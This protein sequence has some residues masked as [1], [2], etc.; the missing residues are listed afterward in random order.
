MK[1]PAHKLPYFV[2]VVAMTAPWVSNFP[3]MGP[4]YWMPELLALL[5]FAFFATSS[6]LDTGFKPTQLLLILLFTFHMMGQAVVG[7]G[8]GG[9]SVTSLILVTS[10]FFVFL[11]MKHVDALD[12]QIIRQLSVLYAV[13]VAFVLFEMLLLK[14]GTSGLLSVLSNGTY[15]PTIADMYTPMPQGIYKDNQAAS[16]ACV[17]AIIWFCMLFLSRRRLGIRFRRAYWAALLGGV[18]A[19]VAYPT[20]TMLAIGLVMYLLAV[21]LVPFLKSNLVRVVSAVAGVVSIE[22]I[23]RELTR[24]FNPE[25]FAHSEEYYR[26]FLGPVETFYNLPLSSKLM[27]A[28]NIES[29]VEAGV[30]D[31]DFGLLIY[32]LRIGILPTIIAA[33]ALL[34]VSFRMLYCSYKHNYDHIPFFRWIWLGCANALLA[35]ANMLSI[36]HYTVSLQ[37]GGRTLFAFHIAVVLL[38]L[39]KI[40]ILRRDQFQTDQY[41]QRVAR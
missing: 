20:T 24:K 9:S 17:F 6:R 27:G 31:A 39:Y 13:H 37:A 29:L 15:K 23:V 11:K 38:S 36:G 40:R 33:G 32:I 28:G 34:L 7:I 30:A 4:F 18:V 41:Q 19:L 26:G 2:T 16:Q 8:I 14:T 22:L 1:F 21:Y 5:A 12:T 3:G 35:I 10:I 25:I